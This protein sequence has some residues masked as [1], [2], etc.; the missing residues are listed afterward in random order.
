MHANKRIKESIKMENQDK[1]PNK[2]QRKHAGQKKG[3][4]A[5]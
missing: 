3:N 2:K 5:A 1:V 4:I